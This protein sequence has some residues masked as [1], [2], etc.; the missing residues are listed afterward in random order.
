MNFEDVLD[1]VELCALP[2]AIYKAYANVLP[3][4]KAKPT[5]AESEE[6]ITESETSESDEPNLFTV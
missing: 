6:E 3:K 4:K 5:L 2:D 1:K